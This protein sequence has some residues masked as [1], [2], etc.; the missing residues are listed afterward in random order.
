MTLPNP[1]T[2][3]AEVTV[4]VLV[5]SRYRENWAGQADFKIEGSLRWDQSVGEPARV[6]RAWSGSTFTGLTACSVSPSVNASV[7][8]KGLPFMGRIS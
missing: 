1:F 7:R 6:R 4:L 2:I 3:W 8:A 5:T